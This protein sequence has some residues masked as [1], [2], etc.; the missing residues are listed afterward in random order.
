M[1]KT[2]IKARAKINLSL[3]VLEK[4]QDGY[5]N[6]KSV[7]QKISL[8]DEIYIEKIKENKIIIETNINEIKNEENIIYKAYEK[9]KSKYNQITGIKVKLNKRIP[10]QAGMAGGST[11][12]ASFLISMNKLFKLEMSQSKI[13]EIGKEL[14]ADVIPCLYDGTTFVEGIGEKVTKLETKVKYYILV[15]KPKM[16]CNTKEMYKR[17][18]EIGYKNQENKTEKIIEALQENNIEKLANNLYNIFEIAIDNQNILNEIKNKLRE[19][20]ALGTLLTGSGACIYG[21]YEDKRKI[22]NA[23][24]ELKDKYETYICVP[25]SK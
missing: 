5:H 21:I 7:F 16:S 3:E 8:Y 20:G 9:L 6:I 17:L 13:E 12:C 14:G 4:R 18:D 15:I 11:D 25:Y 23:Y 24:K 10:I 19:E 2:Y 1:E 22:R